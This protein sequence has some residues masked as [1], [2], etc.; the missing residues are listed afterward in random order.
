[1]N[2]K[3]LLL[4]LTGQLTS[5][6]CGLGISFFLTPYIVAQL[7]QET[8]GFVGLANNVTSYITLFTIAINGMLSRYITVECSKKNYK[9]ASGYLST[10][11]ISQ[12]VLSIV[13]LI[14]MM[15]LAGNVE[16][17]FQ[18]SDGIV[19]DVRF[20]WLLIFLSFLVGLPFGGFGSAA[21][22]KN[23]LEIGSI[24]NIIGNVIRAAT[25]ILAFCFFTPHVWY[26]GFA[27]ILSNTITIFLTVYSKYK[28][29]PELK[30][31]RKYFKFE[32]IKKLVVVGVW[33]SLNRLQQILYT[34]LDLTITNLFINGAEMGILSIAKAIP[35]QVSSL[36][37]T[38]SGTFEPAMTIA[39]GKKDMDDFM[40]QTKFAM[41]FSGFLC[42]VP[43]L[44]F[45]VLGKTFYY[46]WMPSLADAQIIKIHILAVLTLLPQ[47]FSVYVFPLYSVNTITTKLKTPV[48]VSIG[49]G[50]VNVVTVFI[51]LKTTSLGVYA[52]AGVSSILWIFRIFLFVPTYAAWSLKIKLTAFYPTLFKG[53]LNVITICGAF[54]LISYFYTADSW[55]SFFVLC[56]VCAV[57]G[58]ALCFFV[59]F[60]TDER[61]RAI[62]AIKEKFLKKGKSE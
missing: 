25:L 40:R 21:F 8:Y 35:T 37:S 28:L 4:N 41:K 31:S 2:T 34:G 45:A 1:M 59:I 44:A 56:A 36:I 30:V 51:L 48:L 18:V 19:A 52:V 15:L 6:V 10:A 47:V 20:L 9:D 3:R 11:V 23:R 13:L 5:F 53:V 24:I 50:I 43:I 62:T 55:M 61:S 58:Y 16:K 17:I 27:A 29:L 22:A 54:L 14:P 32:Y 39:Y 46:L 42:S 57:I 49:I 33:N 26:I 38:V 60:N 7:G 12:L